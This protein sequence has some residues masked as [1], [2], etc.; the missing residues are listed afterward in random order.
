[1]YTHP[2]RSHFSSI[3]TSIYTRVSSLLC[4]TDRNEYTPLSLWAS[5]KI[6]L[7]LISKWTL[8]MHQHKKWAVKC[9]NSF[10]FPGK[11]FVISVPRYPSW[12]LTINYKTIVRQFNIYAIS[13]CS[14]GHMSKSIAAVPGPRCMNWSDHWAQNRSLIMRFFAVWR[15]LRI[16]WINAKYVGCV[17]GDQTGRPIAV[18]SG[19]SFFGSA[20]ASAT[21]TILCLCIC[22]SGL[23]ALIH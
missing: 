20:S 14:H 13:T 21:A 7:Q 10:W 15:F 9:V 12:S 23:F 3:C 18:K 5:V 1:M 22:L 11:C 2:I 19:V 4:D 6:Y 17:P 16:G 8:I